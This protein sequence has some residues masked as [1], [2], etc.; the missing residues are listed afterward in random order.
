MLSP[1]ATRILICFAC[2]PLQDALGLQATIVSREN[3]AF[4]VLSKSLSNGDRA[5]GLLN[6]GSTSSSYSIPISRI[7]WTKD[8][9]CELEATES[10]S[11]NKTS[12]NACD[13]NAALSTTLASHEVVVWRISNGGKGGWESTGAIFNSASLA[14]LTMAGSSVTW[15][16]CNASDGQVW[17][18]GKK[19]NYIKNTAAGTCLSAS[20]NGTLSLTKCASGLKETV[21]T[22]DTSGN[23]KSPIM[24]Y[25]CLTAGDDGTA[26]LASC[27]N[28]AN[29]QVFELPS[30]ESQVSFPNQ[31]C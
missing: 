3:L 18:V 27:L 31:L 12:V 22:Y 20:T 4:D 13:E 15:E 23:I 14:C 28:L 11:G 19:G 10:F 24:N 5:V 26:S 25:Q 9:G 30:G 8:L 6:N 2:L 17:T 21:F 29:T 7:G 1:Y 16:T